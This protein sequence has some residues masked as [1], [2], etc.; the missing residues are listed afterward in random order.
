MRRLRGQ[1]DAIEKALDEEAEC[2]KSLHT[3]AACHGS[4][5]GLMTE[6]LESLIRFHIVNPDVDP[7]SEASQRR[8]GVDR[9]AQNLF[10]MR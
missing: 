1:V 8:T 5:N 3:M 2:S 10:R 7:K 6:F 4:F 9:C